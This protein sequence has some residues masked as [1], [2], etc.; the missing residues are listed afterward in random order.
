MLYCRRCCQ[1][2]FVLPVCYD[3]NFWLYIFQCLIKSIK[4]YR[5]YWLGD[6]SMYY[7]SF[8]IITDLV[9]KEQHSGCCGRQFCKCHSSSYGFSKFPRCLCKSHIPHWFISSLRYYILERVYFMRD[10][11]NLKLII[12]TVWFY[13][14]ESLLK[15]IKPGRLNW[16][17]SLDNDLK[18]ELTEL[19]KYVSSFRKHNSYAI[20]VDVNR[21]YVVEVIVVAEVLQSTSNRFIRLFRVRSGCH[22]SWLPSDTFK[23]LPTFVLETSKPTRDL[24]PTKSVG[25]DGIIG[26]LQRAIPQY[27]HGCLNVFLILVY[28]G[29]N[30]HLDGKLVLTPIQK[31]RNSSPSLITDW[32][33]F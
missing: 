9:Y 3:W 1:G 5:K 28:D 12:L 17:K 11:R 8:V 20:H 21:T 25:R 14:I 26:S 16:Y 22:S 18:A 33:I 27:L 19:W 23:L 2:R 4:S 6:Y 13:T 7:I 15:L 32:S 31:Y 24:K 30:F 10:R 29:N